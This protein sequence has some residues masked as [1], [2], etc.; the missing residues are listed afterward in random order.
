MS[1]APE[2][3]TT[4][5]TPET[6]SRRDIFKPIKYISFSYFLI[7][8]EIINN[9]DLTMVYY[10]QDVEYTP[11]AL[12]YVVQVYVKDCMV[13]FTGSIPILNFPVNVFLTYAL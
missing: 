4:P 7:H 12:Q 6:P 13:I 2:Q 8:F 11:L 10:L 5:D 1:E 9:G 3:P